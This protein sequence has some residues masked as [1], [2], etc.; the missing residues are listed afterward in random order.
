MTKGIDA[1]QLV[2]E[3]RPYQKS[4]TKKGKKGGDTVGNQTNP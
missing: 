3:K 1:P 2:I 4:K